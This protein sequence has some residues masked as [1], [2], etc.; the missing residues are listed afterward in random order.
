[1]QDRVSLYP[2]RVTLTPVAGQA[3][4]YD[5]ERA[6]SPTQAG[7]PLSKASLLKDATIAQF[8]LGSGAVPD[9]VFAW[10]GKYNEH[11]WSLLH[12][13][14]YSYFEEVRADITQTMLTL[15]EGDAS[16]IFKISK[17]ISIDSSGNISLD[18][19][20]S[21]S[22][23]IEYMAQNIIA[24]APCYFFTNDSA[25]PGGESSTAIYYIPSGST[26]Y[27]VSS[28]RVPLDN[29]AYTIVNDGY[30]RGW[31]SV[32]AAQG[33]R[34]KLVTTRLIQVPAGETTYEHSTDRNAHP[35]SGTVDGIT[36][37]YLSVPF[38]KFPTMPRIEIGSYVGTG[39]YGSDNR[40]R[41]T[42]PFKPKILWLIC[43]KY[44]S[45]GTVYWTNFSDAGSVTIVD[46]G[47]LKDNSQIG[48]G[49]TS[50]DYR[51]Y[52]WGRLDDLTYE[53][54]NTQSASAQCNASGCTYYYAVIG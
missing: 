42:L 37:S 6:D 8:G 3:N 30:G 26:Y 27:Y 19:P 16:N 11:W 45:G 33:I 7:T 21:L 20:T 48:M 28:P 34:A 15:S 40:N 5:M 50:G 41:I 23:N 12:G 2:G 22:G 51:T 46:A 14:A 52:A 31:L 36:Y 38:E 47:E 43:M 32:G 1:M 10:L 18:S 24:N 4:T 49:F 35:D 25:V 44:T 53:W 9:D 17:S 29:P 54:Y 39:T 13:Q